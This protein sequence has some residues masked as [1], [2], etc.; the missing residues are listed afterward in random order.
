MTGSRLVRPATIM[1]CRS[2][3]STVI[4][5]G[6]ML[7]GARHRD[8]PSHIDDV[9]IGDE[10]TIELPDLWPGIGISQMF[11]G[12]LAQ[13]VAPVHHHRRRRGMGEGRVG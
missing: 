3:C 4:L 1:L 7:R 6:R 2:V 12:K 8:L 13:G 10:I 11:P 5:P 9:G